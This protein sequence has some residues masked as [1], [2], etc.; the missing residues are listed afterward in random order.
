MTFKT[1]RVGFPTAKVIAHKM[2][3]CQLNCFTTMGGKPKQRSVQICGSNASMPTAN[4]NFQ[5]NFPTCRIIRVQFNPTNA[6]L[7]GAYSF[8]LQTVGGTAIV[9]AFAGANAG[10]APFYDSLVSNPGLYFTLPSGG[11]TLVQIVD[12]LSGGRTLPFN[13]FDLIVTYLA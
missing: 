3:D 10:A 2:I 9:P 7:T 6:A 1:I 12:T 8:T 5:F 13:L 4:G 11:S